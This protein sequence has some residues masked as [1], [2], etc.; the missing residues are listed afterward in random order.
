[1]P[2]RNNGLNSV[3]GVYDFTSANNPVYTTVTTTYG[4]NNH[5]YRSVPVSLQTSN[6]VVAFPW[7]MDTVIVMDSPYASV[8]ASSISS[9]DQAWLS[10]AQQAWGSAV[11]V[12]DV[13]VGLPYTADSIAIFDATEPP[14]RQLRRIKDAAFQG[15]SKWICAAY[16]P[17]SGQVVGF[18]D[19]KN[20]ILVYDIVHDKVSINEAELRHSWK[21]CDV[22][23]SKVIGLPTTTGKILIYDIEA[24]HPDTIQYAPVPTPP[25]TCDCPA[26]MP[27]PLARPVGGYFNVS[28][29]SCR[30]R[31]YFS[32]LEDAQAACSKNQLCAGVHI[33]ECASAIFATCENPKWACHSRD[34][35]SLK[36]S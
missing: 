17:Q 35:I 23:G 13:A 4:P 24:P 9:S 22:V 32:R 12:G 33:P 8:S 5:Y 14:A 10:P 19:K 25:S 11:A 2:Y 29:Y 18:P 30:G 36:A 20:S 26:P 34:C 31:S 15:Y 21:T 7:D 1:M 6:K 27:G 16:V 28:G 3:I